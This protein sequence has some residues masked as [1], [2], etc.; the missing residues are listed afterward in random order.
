MSN[1]TDKQ[2]IFAQQYILDWNGSRAYKVAY[3]DISEDAAR[4][5]ASRLLTNDNIQAYIREIQIDL[6]K[7]AGISRLMVLNEH[8]K[9]AFNSIAHLHNTWINRKDFDDLTE[10]QKSCIAEIATRIKY[11]TPKEADEYEV[12]EIRI[13]LYDKQKALDSISK[14][15]GYDAAGKIDLTTG[16][17]RLRM[18]IIVDNDTKP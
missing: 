3:P 12:E 17:E 1:I 6:E 2:R 4:A 18:N 11:Y 10:D 9:L 14:M 15:L 16:G 7:Q 5:N 13:K 8:K